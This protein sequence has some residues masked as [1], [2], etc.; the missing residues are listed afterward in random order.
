MT[1]SPDYHVA[2]LTYSVK[3]TGDVTYDAPPPVD[4]ESSEA[5][6]H[7][8]DAKLVCQM[9]IHFAAEA[10]ARVVVEPVL[11]AWELTADLGLG[12][13]GLRFQFEN[14]DVID[15]TPVPPGTGRANLRLKGVGALT[16]VGTVSTHVTRQ[17]YPD[18]PGEF[19]ITPDVDTLWN[20]YQGY[21]EGREPLLGMA[22]FCLTVLDVAAGGR[23]KAARKY[24]IDLP[25]LEAA[26]TTDEHPGGP[27]LRQKDAKNHSPTSVR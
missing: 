3:N 15:R 17:T 23:A 9:K 21:R 13:G 5:R 16:A 11:R 27:A 1:N 8:A 24:K 22:Y 2:S 4:F 7:L 18:P 14:A 12:T 10:E 25:I 20:R 6:F 26:R 19:R